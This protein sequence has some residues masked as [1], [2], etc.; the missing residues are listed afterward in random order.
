MLYNCIHMATVGVKGL[1]NFHDTM[2]L[3]VFIRYRIVTDRQTDGID[4]SISRV[5]FMNECGPDAR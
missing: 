1:K 2:R 5:A 4:I 3:A